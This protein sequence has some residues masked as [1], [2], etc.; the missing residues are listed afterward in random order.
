MANPK[1]ELTWGGNGWKRSERRAVRPFVECAVELAEGFFDEA[2]FEYHVA[3][4]ATVWRWDRRSTIVGASTNAQDFELYVRHDHIKHRKVAASMQD[5]ALT[6]VHEALH[7]IR[8]EHY[9]DY[10]LME[11]VASEG[12]AYVGEDIAQERLLLPIERFYVGDLVQVAATPLF[13]QLKSMLA[14]DD[15]DSRG[16]DVL[17]DKA[18]DAW[19]PGTYN[20]AGLPPG[21]T[22][23]I[24]EIYRRMCEGHEL[25]AL[26]D[27]PAEQLLDL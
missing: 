11:Q 21:L 13:D 10:N 27:W 9:D 24:T 12:I 26:M 20:Y 7:S 5:L 2:G 19:L 23:G 3:K 17:V 8:S 16:D 18:L 4:Q 1:I 22:V 14:Q 6:A 15:K 25:A